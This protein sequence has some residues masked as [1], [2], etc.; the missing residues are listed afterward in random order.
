MPLSHCK[1][2]QQQDTATY[3]L[4]LVNNQNTGDTKGWC[5]H[6]PM[7]SNRNLHAL[8][9]RI[10]NRTSPLED[11]QFLIKLSIFL[12]YDVSIVLFDI[13]QMYIQ[14][15]NTNVYSNSIHNC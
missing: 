6:I 10:Q 14:H 2:K 7:W 1:W 9:V 4:K 11:W 13:C 15:I 8:L 12:T 3:L 5:P